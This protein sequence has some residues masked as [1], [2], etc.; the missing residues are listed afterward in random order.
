MKLENEKIK[1][2]IQNL[3]FGLLATALHTRKHQ[4][5]LRETLMGEKTLTL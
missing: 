1:M 2:T 3:K 4:R 5:P